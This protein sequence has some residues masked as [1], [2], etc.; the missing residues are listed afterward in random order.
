MLAQLLQQTTFLK[1]AAK[2]S[3]CPEDTGLEVVFAGRSNAGKSTVINSITSLK[4]ARTSK[5]PGRTQ[6]LNYFI[7][8]EQKRLVDLPG[9]GYAKVAKSIQQNW[10]KTL[11]EYFAKRQSLVGAILIIDIRHPLKLLDLEL[12]DFCEEKQIPVHILLNKAD[13]L[14]KN[15]Q[16]ETINIVVKKLAHFSTTLTLQLY[17]SPKK[18]GADDLKNILGQWLHLA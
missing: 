9:F 14:S 5:T 6:L 3:D 1:S 4:L 12:L 8:N 13:K 2:L 10:Q 16:Q 11:D 17:S 7:V 15:K 18:I